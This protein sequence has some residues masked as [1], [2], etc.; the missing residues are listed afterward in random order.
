MNELPEPLFNHTVVVGTD[1]SAEAVKLS[2][3]HGV[4]TQ[5]HI[6]TRLTVPSLTSVE[7]CQQIADLA[8]SYSLAPFPRSWL[9]LEDEIR[10]VTS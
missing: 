2:G 8:L 10:R 6:T 1:V 5:G 4:D 9:A 7:Q 3:P